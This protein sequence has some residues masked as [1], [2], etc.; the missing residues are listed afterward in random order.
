[1][2]TTC[3]RCQQTVE[4][5][6]RRPAVCSHCGGSLVKPADDATLDYL[7][8]HG[9][10]KSL[11]GDAVRGTVATANDR[12]GDYQLLRPIGQGGMGQV[13]EAEQAGTGRRVAVKLLSP[14]LSATPE[15]IDR[16]LREGKLAASLSHPRTTFVFGAGQHNGRP[17]IAMEL[18]PGRTLKDVLDEEG[19]LPVARAVD[20]LL[21]V[22]DGLE[23]AHALGVIHRDV[24]PSNC[25][26][27][28][29]GRVKVGDFGLSKSLVSDAELT[30]TGAFLGTPQFA[31]PE[32][33]RGGVV[34]QRTDVYAVGATLF[35]L[36]TGRAPFEGDAVAV[37]AQI[38]SDAAPSLR[39]L[40]PDVRPTLDRVVARALEKD[41]DRRFQDLAHLRR[42]LAGFA[43]GGVSIADVGRRFAAYMVDSLAIGTSS[44]VFVVGLAIVTSVRAAARGSRDPQSYYSPTWNAWF[45]LLF[46]VLQVGYFAA[47]EAFWGRGL[48]KRLMGLRVVGPDGDRPGWL[49]SLVRSCFI[50]GALGLA[51]LPAAL[52]LWRT[53]NLG[54]A[55]SPGLD[56]QNSLLQF[57]PP[58]F[59]LL[60]T[61]SMRARNGYRGWHE[62][63]SGTRVVRLRTNVSSRR[64]QLPVVL[65]VAAANKERRFGPFQVVGDFG[66]SG[67]LTVLQG[68]DEVLGRAVWIYRGPRAVGDA[69]RNVVRPTR[70]HWLQGGEQGNDRWDAF[71]AV[72][73]APLTEI[74]KDPERMKWQES[75]HWLLDLC[76]ELAAA[77]ADGTLPEVLSLSQVWITRSGRLKL[78]DMPLTPLG[79]PALEAETY[80]GPAAER[81][82]SFFRATIAFCTRQQ[83]VPRRVLTFADELTPSA[84]DGQKTL[85][86]AAADLREA[87]TRPAALAWDD[88]L[89]ILAVSMGTEFSFYVALAS[90]LALVLVGVLSLPVTKAVLLAPFVL[91]T[92]AVIGFACRGGPVFWLTRIDVLQSDGRRASRWRCAWRSLLAWA[93]IIVVYGLLGMFMAKA[94]TSSL[95]V[96]AGSPAVQVQ[97]DVSVRWMFL[98]GVCGAELLGLLFLIG[99][100]YAVVRPQ[101]G[102]QDLLSGTWLAPH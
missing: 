4:F 47:T 71:E 6:S 58:L 36:L 46:M 9:D 10:D 93:P 20:Y 102:L 72:T 32:Q 52:T 75:R 90:G 76:E 95:Q 77:L 8:T 31:A 2:Q 70:P 13:W 94:V 66:S 60:C 45:Q 14:R 56:W 27:D 64:G 81:A 61:T 30:R 87:V 89:G 12:I 40:R 68:R 88:R 57:V 55:P 82:V 85:A 7:P 67:D 42:A 101:R 5:A 16:F 35:C 38:V 26:L 99:A 22:I 44:S 28:G 83:I 97:P 23:A 65:P 11:V 41:P 25:F 62:F 43:T 100:V 80:T 34:D 15:N 73:G 3:P 96:D 1:V 53:Q 48:G 54:A 51:A 98:G 29:D 24:K 39:S 18:M 49:R 84:L 91:L 19:P 74:A 63:L 78:L 79:A 86:W 69:R 59:V 37:I 33:V 50:P 92:P 17:Y 21:D